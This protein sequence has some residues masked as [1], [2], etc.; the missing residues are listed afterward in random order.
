MT[1]TG[2]TPARRARVEGAWASVSRPRQASSAT[3]PRKAP[4]S[5]PGPPLEGAG[6]A[7]PPVSAA[8]RQ[9]HTGH[10]GRGRHGP[11]LEGLPVG[12]GHAGDGAPDGLKPVS[13]ER[14]RGPAFPRPS[15]EAPPR[16]GV[17]LGR[18]K[19][20]NGLLVPRVR[21]APD[22]CPSGGTQPT[23]IRVLNRRRDWFRLFQSTEDHSMTPTS[24]SCSPRVTSAVISIGIGRGLTASPPHHRTYGSRIRRF[25]RFRQGNLPPNRSVVSR[26]APARRVWLDDRAHNDA[27]TAG[28]VRHATVGHRHAVPGRPRS[29]APGLHHRQGPTHRPPLPLRRVRTR[30]QGWA[31]LAAAP[32]RRTP[33]EGPLLERPLDGDVCREAHVRPPGPVGPV[34]C[35]NPGRAPAVL[36]TLAVSPGHAPGCPGPRGL[37]SARAHAPSPNLLVMCGLTAGQKSS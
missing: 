7:L 34:G 22:G 18:V 30:Y 3:A 26:R 19:R 32:T 31:A 12:S 33:A 10:S 9:K 5:G 6:P 14:H 21:P 4:H 15:A 24:K 20:P 29:P 1:T 13:W 28:G 37:K 27:A 25:G 17:T 35:S 36:H 2:H 8:D 16:W 23:D 11:S